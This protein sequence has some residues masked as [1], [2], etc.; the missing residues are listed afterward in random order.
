MTRRAMTGIG[1]GFGAA[2]VA[3]FAADTALA[4]RLEDA[5]YA[6]RLVRTASPAPA[7]TPIV[8]V[9]INE[10]TVRALE[11]VFGRWPWPRYV[12]AGAIDY[13][14]RSR[15]RAIAYDVLFTERDVR[16][17]E[18]MSGRDSD[19]ELVAAVRRA[20]NVVLLADTTFGGLAAEGTTTAD[21]TRVTLPGTVYDPG[22][23][24]QSRPAPLGLPFPDLAR[25][26]AAVGHNLLA[27]SAD[28]S[29]LRMPP[30]IEHRGVAVPSLGLAA[31]LFADHVPA[32]DVRLDG[33]TLRVGD[34][35]LPLEKIRVAPSREGEAAEDV[36]S[37]LL[38]FA[39]PVTTA[40]GV[41]STY[42]TYS[43]FDVL[44]SEQRVID[45]EP[46]A[47]PESAFAGKVVFVGTSA[48]ALH[49]VFVTPFDRAGASGI[50]LHAT[51]ADNLISGR[52]MRRV[53]PATDVV[54][55]AGSGLAAGLAAVFLPVPWAIVVVLGGAGGLAALLTWVLGGGAWV[56]SVAP[57]L[58]T[59]LALFGGVA[60]QYAVEGREKRKVRQ[61]F[62][63]YVSRDVVEAL[64]ADPSRAR[65][66]GQRREMTVLFSDIRGFTASTERG[67][68]EAVV[69][70]LNEYFTEMVE[71]LFRNH[72][73]LDK[74]VGDMVMGLFGAPLEDVHHADHAVRAAGEMIAALARLNA[75][76]Q[77]EGRPSVDI[78]IG[79]NTGQMI[80]G[81][82][83]SS[84][85]M[86]Y[87]VIGDAVNLGS[88]LESL[89]K[90]YGTR[91][92][93]SEET[94]QRLTVPV[95]T[96]LVGEV[97]VK[98]RTQPVVVHEV[99]T[100]AAAAAEEKHS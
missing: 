88:R 61:L 60:W 29:A 92:L 43:F 30:F 48:A 32:A 76:W 33:D 13:L 3:W 78:G 57:L 86:S 5:S 67:T 56:G 1:L 83:G 27:K 46:P 87:T 52:V 31:V 47:I 89:N 50:L 98:G 73:T 25:A 91:I 40:D 34:R 2:L 62:G 68:P 65:L 37:A 22:P 55:T 14:S 64:V 28:G 11:P 9:D 74:F 49:D 18:T 35:R 36:W 16:G 80:A 84:A 77:A 94:R 26:A 10:S 71:V 95:E 58:A 97:R 75:R 4:R 59:A 45:G 66:G 41:T 17:T 81:N 20:G 7:D 42:P 38:R 99:V 79:I 23:G 6:A 82:I 12:H 8:L 100:A 54:V 96:R 39:A 44:L 15:A 72:G 21:R 69:A 19:D 53:S 51:Q 24:F 85:I 93:I 63:R 70:Q 90:D